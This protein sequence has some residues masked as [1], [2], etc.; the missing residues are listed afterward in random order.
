MGG[1]PVSRLDPSYE[2]GS[3]I[4]FQ[5]VHEDAIVVEALVIGENQPDEE[6]QNWRLVLQR[7]SQLNCANLGRK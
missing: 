7:C 6:D 1:W 4:T 5:G 3:A 2:L